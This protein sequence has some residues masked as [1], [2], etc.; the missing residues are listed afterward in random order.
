[1]SPL[2]SYKPT[3][4]GRRFA[5]VDA[6]SDITKQE[7]EKK[8]IVIKKRTGG[9]NSQGKITVRHRGGGSKRFIRL[10]DAKRDRFDETAKVLAIE[11]DPNRNARIA[12][13]EYPDKTKS[14]IVAPH[15]LKTGDEIMSS[16]NRLEVKVGNRMPL[17]HIPQGVAIHDVELNPGRGGVVAKGAGTSTQILAVENGYAQ[18]KMP[19]KEIRMVSENCLATIGTVSNP[20]YNLIRWGKAGRMRHRGIKPTVRGKAM[21]PVD[22]PHGGG[23]GHNPIGLKAPKTKWGRKALGVKTRKAKKWSNKF[24]LKRRSK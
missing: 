6:F 5:N 15:E 24:M 16:K 19:S 23:E 13:L 3:T 12:L 10:V 21:N 8:L 1:M 14:Y 7:P 18:I 9:R 11:Y 4:S 17:K 20:D 22:H 2:K